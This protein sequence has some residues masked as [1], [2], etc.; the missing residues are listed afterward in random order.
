MP[1][2]LNLFCLV[3]EPRRGAPGALIFFACY[4]FFLVTE[5]GWSE[6]GTVNFFC[7]ISEP[8]RSGPGALLFFAWYLVP[9][10]RCA[11]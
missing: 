8:G 7:L 4:R 6:P 11:S 1:G 9:D 10:T 2:A 3:P 5:Q